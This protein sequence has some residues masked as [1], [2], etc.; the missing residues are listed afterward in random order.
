M[1]PA[2]NP[3]RS[4][5]G[6]RMKALIYA[7]VLASLPLQAEELQ[8]DL[9]G[10]AYTQTDPSTPLGP[11]DIS[12]M[13]DTAAGTTNWQASPSCLQHFDTSVTLTSVNMTV[14]GQPWLTN[15]Q[16]QAD[17]GG[18]SNSCPGLLLAALVYT[19]GD[20]SFIWEFDSPPPADQSAAALA[21]WL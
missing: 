16:A 6:G 21:A 17:Y 2:Y 10:Q 19:N 12:F 11:F 18:D 15:S 1:Q 14:G 20:I 9:T 8:F 5:T 4:F 13:L 3:G 7:A